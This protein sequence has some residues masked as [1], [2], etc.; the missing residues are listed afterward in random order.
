MKAHLNL[1][2]ITTTAAEKRVHIF[3]FS[4]LIIP[5]KPFFGSPTLAAT[6]MWTSEPAFRTTPVLVGACARL[7]FPGA[8]GEQK[9]MLV[10]VF[11]MRFPNNLGWP[12][13]GLQEPSVHR[14]GWAGR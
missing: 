9:Q 14:D 2:K 8:V 1:E 12:V 3:T 4:L 13:K 6:P 5:T 11:L 10:L 7:G